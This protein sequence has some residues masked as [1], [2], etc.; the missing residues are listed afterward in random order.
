MSTGEPLPAP[1]RSPCFEEG[2]PLLRRTLSTN[3]RR[4]ARIW[5]RVHCPARRGRPG[6]VEAAAKARRRRRC[7][8]RFPCHACATARHA[9]RRSSSP[10]PAATPMELEGRRRRSPGPRRIPRWPPS[11]HPGWRAPRT[12]APRSAPRRRGHRQHR[13]TVAAPPWS[14][15][16]DAGNATL[17]YL[18]ATQQFRATGTYTDRSTA[19]LT[20]EVAWSSS[21]AAGGD[22]GPWVRVGRR[23]HGIG[24]RRHARGSV[25]AS[26]AVNLSTATVGP[27]QLPRSRHGRNRRSTTCW[28][29]AVAG[30]R[31]GPAC[32]PTSCPPAP[33]PARSR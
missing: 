9:E 28:P 8:A 26:A 23:Q 10:R 11:T 6:A 3:G 17:G 32:R 13:F 22:S 31:H 2:R 16:G 4:L 29:A 19:D 25:S 33:P 20:N 21:N 12:G 15:R 7:S 1:Y 14:R 5:R 27:D 30:L 18:G 24:K